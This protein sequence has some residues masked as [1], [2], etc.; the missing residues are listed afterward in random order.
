MPCLLSSA[1][2]VLTLGDPL[3]DEYLRFTAARV[4]PNTLTAQVFDL[5]VFF[6]VVAKRP[7]QVGVHDV[8]EFVE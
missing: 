1:D 3:V 8:L 7:E 5:R 6:T 2:E 4:R